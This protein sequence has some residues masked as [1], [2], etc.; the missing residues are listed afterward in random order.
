[1]IWN[2]SRTNF[3]MFFFMK[4]LLGKSHH[5][6][7]C[8]Y[9]QWPNMHENK[10]VLWQCDVKSSNKV[11]VFL[12]KFL[13]CRGLVLNV[14]LCLNLNYGCFGVWNLIQEGISYNTGSLVLRTAIRDT[15]YQSH[16]RYGES[17]ECSLNVRLTFILFFQSLRT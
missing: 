5:R 8:I 6:N 9:S 13:I 17:A 4:N 7:I 12:L 2:Q 16:P 11:S 10:K 3:P 14:T 15:H 1:M